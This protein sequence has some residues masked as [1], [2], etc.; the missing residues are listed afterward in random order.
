MATTY[1]WVEFFE[2]GDRNRTLAAADVQLQT[3]RN[4]RSG[5]V[6]T[7][8]KVQE[9]MLSSS[10]IS[11]GELHTADPEDEEVRILLERIKKYRV[12]N[13]YKDRSASTAEEVAR[14]LSLID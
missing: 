14:A 12:E 2:T 4:L 7:P 5:D 13:P 6:N 8:I 3:L 1:A 9:S 10:I 11:I